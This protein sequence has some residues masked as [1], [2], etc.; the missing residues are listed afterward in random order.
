[1]YLDLSLPSSHCSAKYE[2]HDKAIQRY[3][4]AINE[5]PMNYWLWYNLCKIHIGTDNLEG[6]ILACESGADK[7]PTSP[8]PLMMLS[9][10]YAAKGDYTG[11]IAK[12]VQFL[13]FKP[14]ILCLALESKDP[15][16]TAE[17]NESD[18]KVMFEP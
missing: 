11:A 7:F 3:Q 17:S 1:M 14:S 13:T 16:I 6:A 15:F 4:N 9:N 2:E 8:S 18:S 5:D 12:S 10:L